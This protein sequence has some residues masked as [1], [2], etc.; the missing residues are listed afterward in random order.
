[1]PMTSG[2]TPAEPPSRIRARGARPYF[3]T[4][5][6]EATTMA[7]APS[8]RVEA[9]PAVTTEPPFTTGRSP[10]RTSAVVPGRGPSSVSTTVWAPFFP[11]TVTGTVSSAKRPAA[12]AA[13]ARSCERTANASQSSRE[14]P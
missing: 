5:A 8:F 3:S 10:A 2:A 14:V 11:V 6:S 7:E 12:I 1:M 13:S 9:L 4:A